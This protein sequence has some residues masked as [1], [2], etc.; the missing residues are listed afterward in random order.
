MQLGVNDVLYEDNQGSWTIQITGP[1]GPPATV[2]SGPVETILHNF[3]RNDG[4]WPFDGLV[5]GIDGNFYGTTSGGGRTNCPNGCGTVFR[6]SSDGTFTNLYLFT[7]R[8]NDGFYPHAGLVQGTDGNF[9]GTTTRGG[10]NTT[11]NNPG[12]GT[13]FRI[14]PSGTYTTLHWFAG[15]PSD[16]YYPSAGLVQGTDGNFYGTTNNGGTNNS[17]TIFRITPSGTETTLYSFAGSPSDGEYPL[18]GLVQ[19]DDGNFYGTTEMGGSISC[20]DNGCF[21]N[22]TVFR[23]SPSGTY[24]TLWFFTG[25][26]SDGANPYAGLVQGSDGNFYGTTRLGGTNNNGMVFRITPSG[27]CTNLYSF[28]GPP[29]DGALPQAA[30]VQGSDGN[31]YGTTIYAGFYGAG[32]VFRITPEG[33]YTNLYSF[34]GPPT[35][36]YQPIAGLV[37]GSDGNFYGT[38]P[39][40][41]SSEY[42]DGTVFKLHVPLNPP[43]NQ[44]AGLQFLSVFNMSY[45]AILVPSVAGETYQLQYTDS[46]N[47]T[48]WISSGDPITSIG[49]PLT[50]FDLVGT[51]T[52]QRFYRFVITP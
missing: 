20:G 28:T 1:A 45:T 21:G 14:S 16:G 43:A 10:T 15:Y 22:G 40:G 18:A 24:T 3:V 34:G 30:L 8:P 9:Y 44:I 50:T 2:A 35:D 4:L 26:P 25:Y 5:Q 38:T 36:G 33:N 11:L 47:P 48:N 42:G 7:G 49:G 31:F 12:A 46:M 19:G 51:M 29:D 37:Q 17:G 23:I 27:S 39:A 41:V 52:P 13:V 32:I 6:I